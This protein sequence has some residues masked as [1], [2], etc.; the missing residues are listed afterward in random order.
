[1]DVHDIGEDFAP[2]EYGEPE[3][4]E[5]NYFILLLITA[6]IAVGSTLLLCAN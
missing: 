3:Q 6:V 4:P 2:S 5:Y 1:M